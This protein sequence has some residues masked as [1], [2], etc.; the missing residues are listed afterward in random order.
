[1]KQIWIKKTGW[2]YLPVNAAGCLVTIGA[3]LFMVPVLIAADRSAHSVTDEL[4]EIFVFGSC[5]AFWWD[6]IAK[7]KSV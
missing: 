1:M 7:R 6:W 5:A 3:I 2:F 4:Y